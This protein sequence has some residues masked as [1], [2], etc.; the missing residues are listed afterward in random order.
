MSVTLPPA[1]PNEYTRSLIWFRRDLR[2]R[3][4]RTFY[5]ATLWS[6]E[7]VGVFVFDTTILD[8]LKNPHDRRVT[9]I[10]DSVLELREKFRQ[11]GSDL[12]IEHGDPIEVLPRLAKALKAD[13]IFVGKDFEPSAKKRDQTVQT[14]VAPWG[15][16][17]HSIKDQVVFAEREVLN[18]SG[19]VFR[20][21]TPYK[22]AWLRQSAEATE[23]LARYNPDFSKLAKFEKIKAHVRDWS[24]EEIGFQRTPLWLE[25]GEGAAIR[26]LRDFSKLIADYKTGRDFPSAEGT[27]GLSVHLRFGTISVRSCARMAQ[28]FPSEGASTWLSELIWRDFYHM[29]LDQYPHVVEGCFKPEYDNLKWP[30]S[31]EHFQLWCEGKTGFP[32]V[33]AAMRHF[34]ETGW[35]HNRLRMIVAM[36]L[37]KDLLCDYKWGEAYFA[38][39]L[40]DFDLAANNGGWQW[41]AST[42]CDAQPYFRIFNPTS[43]SEKFDP[44]GQFIKAQI[45]ELRDVD[46]KSIHAPYESGRAVKNY[47]APIVDHSAQRLKALELFKKA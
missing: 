7:V 31:R 5:Q 1:S 34:N 30:G 11:N 17:F 10:F 14:R 25:A 12:I 46:A 21:F 42:G 45:P 40:L 20:V 9:F 37:T 27:S 39:H 15:C 22:N 44:E 41:S 28:K 19:G 32:I 29:I 4:H 2:I 8:R 36:F 6:R 38:K 43:Q 3:D 16:A 18:Q 24:L 13:A 23:D 33:D 35:M 47:P 26:R